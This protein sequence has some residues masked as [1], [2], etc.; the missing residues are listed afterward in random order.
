[1]ELKRSPVGFEVYANGLPGCRTSPFFSNYRAFDEMLRNFAEAECPG[2]R[3]QECHLFQ[4]CPVRTCYKTNGFDF[5][6]QYP[7]LRVPLL[8]SSFR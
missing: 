6:F 8:E 3:R 5:Y 1:M 4:L 2:C 7:G